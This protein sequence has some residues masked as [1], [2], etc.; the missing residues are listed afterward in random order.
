MLVDDK[1]VL[2]TRLF[3]KMLFGEKADEAILKEQGIIEEQDVLWS[4]RAINRKRVAAVVHNYMKI[5]LGMQDLQDISKAEIVNDLYDCRVCANHIAQVYLRDIMGAYVYTD[6]TMPRSMTYSQMADYSS[7]SIK[8]INININKHSYNMI[9]FEGE[10]TISYE[11]A[12]AIIRR[13]E[14]LRINVVAHSFKIS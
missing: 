3:I 9:L 11:D 2:C 13:L 10:R 8:D 14:S 6:D 12:T 5:V 1:E 7:N 4:D